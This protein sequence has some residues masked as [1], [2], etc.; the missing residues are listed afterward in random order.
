MADR[1]D[2]E[3]K[4]LEVL[5]IYAMTGNAS[6]AAREVK[7]PKRTAQRWIAKAVAESDPLL[8][9][10]GAQLR[11]QAIDAATRLV[12]SGIELAHDRAHDDDWCQAFNSDPGPQYIKSLI[13]ARKAL[14]VD[15]DAASTD[16]AP[17][18]VV[19]RIGRTGEQQA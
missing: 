4:R 11:A 6:R 17:R 7:I 3:K 13:D 8:A 1:H 18:D 10:H 9:Q 16:E 5:A 12:L 14:A 15:K 2:D 19:I